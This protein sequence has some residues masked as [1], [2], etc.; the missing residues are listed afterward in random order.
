LQLGLLTFS[1]N[2]DNAFTSTGFQN[3]KKAKEKC[4][5]HEKTRTHTEA[6]F[7]LAAQRQPGVYSIM[8]NSSSRNSEQLAGWL[9]LTHPEI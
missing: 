7:K 3:W 9:P 1:K 2:S 6:V 5:T 8:Q 4:F